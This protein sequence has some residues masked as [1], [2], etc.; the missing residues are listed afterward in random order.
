[1]L[2]Y[3]FKFKCSDGISDTSGK[4]SIFSSFSN[5]VGGPNRGTS[6][7]NTH[8]ISRVNDTPRSCA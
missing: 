2:V 7:R 4:T 3:T 8:K 6:Y 1:M 5:H